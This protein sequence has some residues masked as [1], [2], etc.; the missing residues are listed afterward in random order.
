MTKSVYTVVATNFLPAVKLETS[1]KTSAV[2]AVC[3]QSF[4][5]P[6][7]TPPK[8]PP[9]EKLQSSAC[10]GG[11]VS[12][13]FITTSA[14]DSFPVKSETTDTT[15]KRSNINPREFNFFMTAANLSFAAE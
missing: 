13:G 7:R 15:M 9:E 8:G 12:P 1:K 3:S 10:R 2:L 4:L 14:R 5:H 11:L 6:T